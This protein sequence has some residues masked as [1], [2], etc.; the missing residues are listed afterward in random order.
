MQKYKNLEKLLIQKNA[1]QTKWMCSRNLIQ[2]NRP[3]QQAD[4]AKKNLRNLK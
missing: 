1:T 3:P 2:K 4:A